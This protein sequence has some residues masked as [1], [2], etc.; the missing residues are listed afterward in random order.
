MSASPTGEI[1]SISNPSPTAA[2]IITL[3]TCPPFLQNPKDNS[4]T[5]S[6]PQNAVGLF[7]VYSGSIYGH[8]LFLIRSDFL[9]HFLY[10]HRQFFFAFFTGFGIDIAGDP[11]AVGIS[12]RVFSLPEMVV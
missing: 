5:D 7:F 3:V 11:L 8:K 9:L 10:H 2:K 6:I 12:G 1:Q 4:L